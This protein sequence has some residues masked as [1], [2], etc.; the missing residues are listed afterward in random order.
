M[1]SVLPAGRNVVGT[2]DTHIIGLGITDL[3]LVVL[4]RNER[5][6]N[7][8]NHFVRTVLGGG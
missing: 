3:S 4:N 8:G 7:L 1:N 2:D 6:G 5:R